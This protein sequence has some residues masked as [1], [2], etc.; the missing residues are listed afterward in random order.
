LTAK[1]TGQLMRL[2]VVS[3]VFL[4]VPTGVTSLQLSVTAIRGQTSGV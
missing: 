4:T 2:T 3:V 1:D